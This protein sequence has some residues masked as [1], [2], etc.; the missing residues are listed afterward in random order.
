VKKGTVDNA[1]EEVNQLS[2][3]KRGSRF[4]KCTKSMNAIKLDRRGVVYTVDEVRALSNAIDDIECLASAQQQA[5][6]GT[7]RVRQDVRG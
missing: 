6:A 1:L 7:V 3:L 5:A 4:I 2:Q